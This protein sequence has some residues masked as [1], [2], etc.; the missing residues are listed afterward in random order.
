MKKLS[1]C[2][3]VGLMLC[4]DVPHTLIQA[5]TLNQLKEEQKQLEQ[6]KKTAEQQLEENKKQQSALSKE[7]DELNQNLS[8]AQADLNEVETQ[9]EETSI[10]LDTAEKE[11]VQ[12]TAD[13]EKQFDAFSKRIR[14]IHENG[15]IGYL[16]IVLN[17]RDFTDLLNRMEYVNEIMKY[18]EETL[19]RLKKSEELIDAKTK[20]I[21]KEK[22]AKES[23]VEQ[24]RIKTAEFQGLLSQKQ[25]KMEEYQKD[26]ATLERIAKE[27]ETA[28]NEVEKLI[29]KA[30][31]EAAAK[32]RAS[33]SA[34]SSGSSASSSGGGSNFTYSGGKLGWPV[35]GRTYVSSG[36]VSRNSPVGRGYEFHTGLDIPAPYGYGIQA[37]EA[38]TVITAGW[39]NGYGNCVI[40]SHGNGLT[41]LYG[42][43]SSLVVSVGDT[44]SRG[45]VI[46]KCG[47]TGYA[48]GNHCHF[49]VRQNGKAV[50]PWNYVN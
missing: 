4:S 28:S 39:V 20:E 25:V 45:Q 7:I 13:K 32:A 19:D 50:N 9:L 42:H 10:R 18:D 26:A 11:L 17:S 41:T 38:G 31:A 15:S 35:P 5:K 30:E 12:A 1:L 6:K 21:A 22:E 29:Q 48:T 3:L 23:L 24:Q 8:Q 40:I 36:F 46:A 33:A 44:V 27:N 43:N 47:A 2:I 14:Y 34:G 49:E 16:N 37:A